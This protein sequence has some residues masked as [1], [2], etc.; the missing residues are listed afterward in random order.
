MAKAQTVLLIDPIADSK[1]PPLDLL[2]QAT[3]LRHQGFEPE[4]RRGIPDESW[5]EP[6]QAI[7]TAVFSWHYSLLQSAIQA[8]KRLWPHAQLT[9]SGVLVRRMGPELGSLLGVSVLNAS[10]EAALDELQPDYSI[11]PHW[12]ASILVTSKGVC[13]RECAHCDASRR[14]KGVARIV[15]SWS[16][17]LHPSLPR[18]EVWDNTLMLTPR[19]HYE[20]VANTLRLFE[21]SVDFVCG[22]A[23]GGV[24]EEELLWRIGCLRGV[25]LSPVRLECNVTSDLDRF[26]RLLSSAQKTFPECLDLRAFAV[27][28]GYENPSEAWKRLEKI[29]ATGLKVEPILFT[30]HE[31]FRTETYVHT[32]TGWTIQDIKAFQARW[33]TPYGN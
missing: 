8:A 15:A 16:N 20:K 3:A 10:I 1:T 19:D 31:W 28:N 25:R 14:K 18:V 26:H 21:R 17:H 12:D 24:P 22:I 9:L 33:S 29:E 7:F 30:P 13:P 6:G 23:P 5:P 2:R 4:F 32:V 27:I 11:V